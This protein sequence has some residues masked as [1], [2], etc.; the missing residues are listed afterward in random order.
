MGNGRSEATRAQLF[1]TIAAMADSCV[2]H[3][4]EEPGNSNSLVTTTVSAEA[5]G[6]KGLTATLKK[7]LPAIVRA[8]LDVLQ[9]PVR[10]AYTWKEREAALEVIA[11]IAVLDDLRGVEGPLGEYRA[12][13]IEGASRG[14]HDSVAAVRKAASESLLLLEAIEAEERKRTSHTF[15]PGRAE[16]A[17]KWG[18]SGAAMST[19]G[20]GRT[21]QTGK[22]ICSRGVI[23]E[24]GVKTL[25]GVLIKAGRAETVAA[26]ARHHTTGGCQGSRQ[27]NR[28]AVRQRQEENAKDTSQPRTPASLAPS[29]SSAKRASMPIRDGDQQDPPQSSPRDSKQVPEFGRN[30]G[31]QVTGHDEAESQRLPHGP[32]LQ[33][34]NHDDPEEADRRDS[35]KRLKAARESNRSDDMN[36]LAPSTQDDQ[37]GVPEKKVADAARPVE[38]EVTRVPTEPVVTSA[39]QQ[40]CQSPL[41]PDVVDVR[42]LSRGATPSDNTGWAG[43]TEERATMEGPSAL[44]PPILGDVQ[45]DTIRLLKHLNGTTHKI[46]R[47][48][49]GLDQRLREMEPKLVVRWPRSAP[50]FRARSV[51]YGE[52]DEEIGNYMSLQRFVGVREHPH[53]D[54]KYVSASAAMTYPAITCLGDFKAV[55]VPAGCKK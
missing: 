18:G 6:A 51:F 29:T 25:E 14:K 23:K 11:A 49:D 28:E 40:P 13:L 42:N 32:F 55:L 22:Q 45:V 1:K 34:P 31:V 46:A 37:K 17:F 12:K 19:V 3:A 10:R 52:S 15:V 36:G 47:V 7:G 30:D 8:V 41:P 21:Y 5:T 20:K 53:L 4:K 35:S 38:R 26:E 33:T 27:D 48:L 24:V 43:S 9:C 54:E 39:A 50:S 44:R 2:I 16:M